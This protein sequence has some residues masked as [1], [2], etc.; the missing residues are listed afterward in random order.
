MKALCLA[1]VALSFIGCSSPKDRAR[2][3]LLDTIEHSIRLPAGARPFSS[4]ARYYAPSGRDEVV[5]IFILPGLDELPAGEGCEELREIGTSAP[6]SFDWP[7]STEVGAGNRVWL[8]DYAK[9]PMPMRDAR[10]CG[11]ISM[12]YQTSKRRFIEVVCY[13]ESETGY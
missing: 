7:K 6:C 9:L 12:V 13:G 8:S 1:V 11:L 5:G 4:Y 2:E 10:N 3:Q